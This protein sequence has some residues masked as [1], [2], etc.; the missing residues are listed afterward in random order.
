MGKPR[1]KNYWYGNSQTM[2]RRYPGLKS[3]KGLQ[4]A[5]WAD[6]IDRALEETAKMT[7]G[8]S[9]IEVIR[10][11]HFDKTDTIDGAALKVHASRRTV[12]RW[13]SAFINLVG[14]N[15]GFQ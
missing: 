7:D 14:R 4:P 15:A 3:E 6:A 12:Q 2:I 9:R 8:E 11:I 13:N 5:M 1:Y 10:L